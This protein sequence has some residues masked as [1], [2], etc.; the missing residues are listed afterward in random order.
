M[1]ALKWV[2]IANAVANI[3]LIA[4]FISVVTLFILND[5]INSSYVIISIVIFVVLSL[6][7]IFLSS[8]DKKIVCNYIFKKINSLI[9]ETKSTRFSVSCIISE[10][11]NTIEVEVYVSGKVSDDFRSICYNELLDV[12]GEYQ[13][14]K[15]KNVT[16]DIFVN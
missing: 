9:G 10:R 16:V 2:N 4:S 11:R 7:K 3:L 8:R 15:N 12:L 6:L 14:Y 13:W 1:K 5:T